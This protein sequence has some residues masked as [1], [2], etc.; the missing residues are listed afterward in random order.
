MKFTRRLLSML[1]AGVLFATPV[2]GLAN[3]D[4]EGNDVEVTI[5][6]E[7]DFV[8]ELAD[9]DVVL[10]IAQNESQN[11]FTVESFDQMCIERTKEYREK[12]KSANLE[13]KINCAVFLTNVDRMPESECQILEGVQVHKDDVRNGE[14]RNFI[15]AKELFNLIRDYNCDLVH[16][17]DNYIYLEKIDFSNYDK[18]EFNK[19]LTKV[20][21][22]NNYNLMDAIRDYNTGLKDETKQI[23]TYAPIVC[24]G[25]DLSLNKYL[26][27]VVNEGYDL[28][29][30]ITEY[31]TA[32]LEGVIE[33]SIDASKLIYDDEDRELAHQIH[34]NWLLSNISVYGIVPL[35]ENKYYDLARGQL[36]DLKGLEQEGNVCELSVGARFTIE[37]IYG[38]SLVNTIQ[39]YMR[40]NIPDEEVYEY[41]DAKE[42]AHDQ[43][44]LRNDVKANLK[45]MN[46]EIDILVGHRGDL[47]EYAARKVNSD[48]MV[49]LANRCLSN[50]NTNRK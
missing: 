7:T 11:P 32:L 6:E 24:L 41:Y 47:V 22:N 30:A 16:E 5:T 14:L 50:E 44:V 23:E 4:V 10:A 29:N 1:S 49:Y 38:V 28:V 15:D 39:E 20:I 40:E 12:I 34:I 45:E 37:G 2:A 3:G 42:L 35:T 13:Q 43:W 21:K 25:K 31:N 46:R 18:E 48:L 9:E 17:L 27:K 33:K 26:E 19:F 8:D 36:S